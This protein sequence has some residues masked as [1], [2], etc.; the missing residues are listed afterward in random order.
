MN[1]NQC[2]KFLCTELDKPIQTKKDYRQWALRNH[3]DKGGDPEEM[4][5][6]GD[7]TDCMERL[8]ENPID[9]KVIL[10]ENLKLQLRLLL[11]QHLGL[12]LMLLLSLLQSLR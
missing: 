2:R 1:L 6:N 11:K 8:N 9:Y 5:K 12:L 4:K 3:P 7:I 10:R